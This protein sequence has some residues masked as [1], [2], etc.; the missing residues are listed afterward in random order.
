M[1]SAPAWVW[2][3][4][5]ET[6]SG[7]RPTFASEDARPGAAPP[8]RSGGALP[9]GLAGPRPRTANFRGSRTR[10]GSPGADSAARAAF[11]SIE[12]LRPSRGVSA[13]PL[14]RSRVVRRAPETAGA[15][16]LGLCAR[17]SREVCCWPGVDLSRVCEH[18]SVRA[19]VQLA[20][21]QSNFPGVVC[22]AMLFL[23]PAACTGVRRPD[24]CFVK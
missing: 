13:A 12:R 17:A 4:P 21:R 8:F 6:W 14:R 9:T 1:G 22:W 2:G 19:A 16:V 3:L 24:S 10:V 18:D 5:S 20:V 11:A 23:S 7:V 15:A